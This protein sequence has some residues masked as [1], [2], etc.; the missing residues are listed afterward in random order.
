MVQIV[1]GKE[2]NEVFSKVKR[3]EMAQKAGQQVRVVT[4]HVASI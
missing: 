4:Y 3:E 1:V 2:V